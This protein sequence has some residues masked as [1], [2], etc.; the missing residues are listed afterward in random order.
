MYYEKRFRRPGGSRVLPSGGQSGTLHSHDLFVV[1]RGWKW[2]G[3]SLGV[4]SGPS[5]AAHAWRRKLWRH[6]RLR[7]QRQD[8]VGKLP[9]W[10]FQRHLLQSGET[11]D[12]KL[13]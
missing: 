11:N 13:E 1:M 2:G 7:L 4:L 8:T 9:A 10:H 6:F 3:A 12:R 5:A